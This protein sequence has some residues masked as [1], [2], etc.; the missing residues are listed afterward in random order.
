L[1]EAIHHTGTVPWSIVDNKYWKKFFKALGEADF[2]T[3]GPCLGPNRHQIGGSLLNQIDHRLE[4]EVAAIVTA[5]GLLKTCMMDGWDDEARMHL[6]MQCVA[7]R[8]GCIFREGIDTSDLESIDK[9]TTDFKN[10][11]QF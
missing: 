9:P 11:A 5:R 2:R 6:M 8:T 7:T 10:T 3:S 1:A 4:K